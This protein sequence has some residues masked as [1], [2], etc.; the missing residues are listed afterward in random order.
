MFPLA[1]GCSL[2]AVS[3]RFY[4]KDVRTSIITAPA[5]N[6]FCTC[7][8]IVIGSRTTQYK[9]VLEKQIYL[10]LTNIKQ[11]EEGALPPHWRVNSENLKRT[12]RFCIYFALFMRLFGNCDKIC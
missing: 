7:T 3:S 8:S 6:G 12:R 9:E 1:S 5:A 10:R 2:A 11:T 4:A